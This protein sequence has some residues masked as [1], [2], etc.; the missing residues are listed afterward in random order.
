MLMIIAVLIFAIWVASMI[1]LLHKIEETDSIVYMFLMGVASAMAGGG[2][3][4]VVLENLK[5]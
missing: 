1:W 2:L 5:F 4:G 3:L